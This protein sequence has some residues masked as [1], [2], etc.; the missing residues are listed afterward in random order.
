MKKVIILLLILFFNFLSCLTVK[1]TSNKILKKTEISSNDNTSDIN[2]NF[3]PE[4]EEIKIP[5]MIEENR[6]FTLLFDYDIK[7]TPNDTYVKNEEKSIIKDKEKQ[8]NSVNKIKTKKNFLNKKTKSNKVDDSIKKTDEII[9]SK[10]MQNDQGEYYAYKNEVK[11]NKTMTEIIDNNLQKNA[12]VNEEQ[13]I[14]E[15]ND[16]T[17]FKII[18]LPLKE[19]NI[20]EN[21]DFF[22]SLKSPGW[23]LKEITPK[24]IEFFKR[25][26]FNENT[27]FHFKS[28]ASSKINVGFIRYDLNNK[29][30]YR[31]AYLL[32]IMPRSILSVEK[33][34]LYNNTKAEPEND[35]ENDYLR[36]MAN[37]QFDQ[38][39]YTEA[40]NLYL[41]LVKDGLSDGEIYYKLGIIEKE[42]GDKNKAVEHFNN[43]IKEKNNA[44]YALALIELIKV[45]KELKRYTEAINSYYKIGTVSN[46][47]T[48]LAEDLQLLLADVYHEMKDFKSAS[49][50]YRR[51]MQKYPDSQKYD[52]ALFYLAYSLESLNFNA[53]YK[54][55]YRLYE[56]LIK[57]F[58]E[59]RYYNLSKKRILYLNRH[60]LKIN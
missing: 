3:I 22:I 42:T 44:Y 18:E 59:S 20:E 39:K 31:Q 36:N 40:K 43:A 47:N 16:L 56:L 52:K 60:F 33:T 54:E 19:V 27:L 37:Q 58:P 5:P 53:D 1:N 41:T 14:I 6:N 57:D 35:R 21:K 10:N 11:E 24:L 34:N 23:L 32:N 51:F 12:E 17:E 2:K 7:K 29:T 38:K 49:I 9:I 50:E 4:R 30:I 26:N 48:I 55:A 8:V 25:E 15:E 46:M 13:K 45:Y 28:S